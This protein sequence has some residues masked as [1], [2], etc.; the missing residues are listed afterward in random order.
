MLRTCFHTQLIRHIWDKLRAK[1][2]L[3]PFPKYHRAHVSLENSILIS[4]LLVN[5]C[6][7]FSILGKT[8]LWLILRRNIYI[9]IHKCTYTHIIHISIFLV[10]FKRFGQ[11]FLTFSEPLIFLSSWSFPLTSKHVTSSVFTKMKKKYVCLP[12][13]YNTSSLLTFTVKHL[14]EL[15]YTHDPPVSLF[16]SLLDSL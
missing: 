3:E 9:Y 10:L 1:Y 15:L 2:S 14:E 5:R 6:S 13:S 7:I 11:C 12:T 8:L 16:L 4:R